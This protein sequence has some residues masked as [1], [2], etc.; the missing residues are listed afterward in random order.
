[1]RMPIVIILRDVNW[2]DHASWGIVHALRSRLR[3]SRILLLTSTDLAAR[4]VEPHTLQ[5][6]DEVIHLNPLSTSAVAHLMREVLQGPVSQSLVSAVY[7]HTEGFAYAVEWSVRR[8]VR[9][10]LLGQV[11]G[12]YVLSD[13]GQAMLKERFDLPTVI[14]ERL[15]LL[16]PRAREVL[17]MAA[18][19]GRTFWMDSLNAV[20]FQEAHEWSSRLVRSEFVIR[21]TQGSFAHGDEYRFRFELEWRA[22]CDAISAEG[23]QKLNKLAIEWLNTFA[24]DNL[25]WRSRRADHFHAMEQFDEAAED[26]YF[27]GKAAFACGSFRD[28]ARCMGRAFEVAVNPRLK[29]SS[30]F[31]RMRMLIRLGEVNN[32]RRDLPD[33][34]ALQGHLVADESTE[35]AEW[36][37]RGVL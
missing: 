16:D 6:Y 17:E 21:Q 15:A 1:M 29:A 3:E 28:A 37:V 35:L 31:H 23:S 9:G 5:G 14:E 19:L 30:L 20:G 36:Q 13:A 27:I 7:R 10:N 8:L 4:E 2:F 26:C 34:L 33:M 25:Q 22:I 11:D 24:N 18:L 32:A 12:F